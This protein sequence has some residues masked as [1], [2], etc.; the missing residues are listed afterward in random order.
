MFAQIRRCTFHHVKTASMFVQRSLNSQ[1]RH[2]VMTRNLTTVTP[3]GI[4]KTH[5]RESHMLLG[6]I[7]L[8]SFSFLHVASRSRMQT[9][10]LLKMLLIIRMPQTKLH[11]KNRE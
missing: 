5:I 8:S 3:H 4:E 1:E 2:F 11:P 7:V 10:N 9:S 6:C